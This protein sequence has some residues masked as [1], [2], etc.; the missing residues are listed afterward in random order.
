M[1]EEPMNVLIFGHYDFDVNNTVKA[2][3]K[4]AFKN[5][6]DKRMKIYSV[7]GCGKEIAYYLCS[8]EIQG[9]HIALYVF[10]V[11]RLESMHG[12]CVDG[13]RY[14]INNIPIII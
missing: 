14:L 13:I 12:Q 5:I 7:S 2:L 11:G 1:E 9:Y 8:N 10:K 6:S 4:K 3:K